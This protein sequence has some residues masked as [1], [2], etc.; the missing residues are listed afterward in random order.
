MFESIGLG[1]NKI[2]FRAASDLSSD[3]TYTWPVL[4]SGIPVGAGHYVLTGDGGSLA[5]TSLANAQLGT[6]IYNEVPSGTVNGS[7]A[8]FSTANGIESGTLRVYKNGLRQKP[9]SG[10]DYTLSG[11]EITFE[12]G[13]IPQTGDVILVDYV[14]E[15]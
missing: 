3:S 8:L 10:Y 5:W 12:S 15:Q 13:N 4:P 1:T 9:G 7:N 2:I 14:T 6:Q 11:Q